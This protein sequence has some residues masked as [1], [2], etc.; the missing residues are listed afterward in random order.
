MERLS[1][2][3]DEHIKILVP[4]IKSYIRDTPNFIRNIKDFRQ[5]GHYFLVTMD[6]M[7]LYMNIPNREGLVAVTRSL[8]N[9]QPQFTIT[10]QSC[11]ELLRL[12]LYKNNFNFNE[13]HYLQIS[14]M[15]MGTKV[16]PSLAKLFMGC[17]E[18]K[19]LKKMRKKSWISNYH[20]TK[21]I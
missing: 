10:Y 20:Y 17:L 13:E 11:L 15:A 6:V 14:G 3:V 2:F 16:A 9:K 21:D 5:A 1:A 18:E 12:V 8:D 4:K 7:S 19:L